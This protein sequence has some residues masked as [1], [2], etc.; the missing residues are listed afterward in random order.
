MIDPASFYETALSTLLKLETEVTECVAS[1]AT[2]IF[3][4]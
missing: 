2:L 3:F 4:L 1:T